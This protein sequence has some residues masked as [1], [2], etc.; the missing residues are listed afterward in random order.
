MLAHFIRKLDLN[1]S[2]AR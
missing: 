1:P 2:S